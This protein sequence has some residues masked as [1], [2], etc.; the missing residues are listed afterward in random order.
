M[1][2]A[3][4]IAG[5]ANASRVSF[6]ILLVGAKA[7]A[8]LVMA[9]RETAVHP[10]PLH[11]FNVMALVFYYALRAPGRSRPSSEM[12]MTVLSIITPCYNERSRHRTVQRAVRAVMTASCRKYDYEHILSTICSQIANRGD[13]PRD[14]GV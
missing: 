13:S 5:D 9:S 7:H 12:N 2:E 6:L 11:I 14:R 8:P 1:S 3:I 4:A 10:R